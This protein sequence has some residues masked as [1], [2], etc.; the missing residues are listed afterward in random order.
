MDAVGIS[1]TDRL[2]GVRLL[3]ALLHLGNIDFG[4]EDLAAVDEEDESLAAAARLLGCE[5]QHLGT[6]LCSRKLKAGADWVTTQNTVAQAS[7]VR[8]A[9]AKQLYSF[10]F[11]SLVKKI[12]GSL[13]YHEAGQS[14][15]PGPH[16]AYVDIFGF[17]VF[18]VNSLEQLCINFANEKLQRLFCGVLFESVQKM[19]EF[20]EVKTSP[21]D[22]CVQHYAGDV[23][24]NVTGFLEKNKDPIS[25]DLQVRGGLG[26]T[27]MHARAADT[28]CW[29]PA[30]S[31]RVLR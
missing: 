19:S 22:F 24:Y 5:P 1:S 23:T 14:Y 7:D 26:W 13:E 10:Y 8:H 21:T 4:E 18:T 15:G 3:A 17:E 27:R 12:N 30:G 16:I 31:C 20:K 11:T 28:L 6:G 9:L 25:Q 29:S 2:G